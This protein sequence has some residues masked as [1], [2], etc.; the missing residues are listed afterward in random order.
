M[1]MPAPM[2]IALPLVVL[3][4]LPAAPQEPA[5]WEQTWQRAAT[6]MTGGKAAEAIA[7]LEPVVAKAPAFEAAEYE[8]GRAHE[9]RAGEFVMANTPDDPARRRHLEQ[10][11]RLY[12][13][14]A[15][16]N[17]QYRLPA[18]GWLMWIYDE[19]DLDK[20]VERAVAARDYIAMSPRSAL[21]YVARA[22]ALRAAGQHDAAWAVLDTARAAVEPGDAGS[23][24][25]AILLHLTEALP[26]V[27]AGGTPAG[28]A[29]KELARL[30]DYAD[31]TLARELAEN[32]SDRGAILAKAA[33]L[34]LRAQRL[35]RDPAKRKALE[36]EAEALLG[37]NRAASAAS[38]PLAFATPA[39]PAGDP[40]PAGY[41]E[42]AARATT[43]VERKQFAEAMAIYDGFIASHPGFAPSH[44]QRVDVLIRSGQGALVAPALRA[45]RKAVAGTYESRQTG[46]TYLE[47]IV[48]KN[49]AISVADGTV[50]LGEALVLVDEALAA[51]PHDVPALVYK[52]LIVRGQ[53]RFAPD[54]AAAQKLTAEA[55]RL[56][57][58]AQAVRTQP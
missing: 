35:E 13:R 53:A 48:R 29:P 25:R 8:L 10:A 37:R 14:V 38:A 7:L 12:Q 34:S 9:F 21:G 11:A 31:A 55:D 3:S 4:V 16:R 28:T 50:A 33:S 19:D 30:L 41:Y 20:P 1:P 43:L 46:A 54:A 27:T 40:T 26:F 57:A 18:L 23:L 22:A 45:A 44:Y 42:A 5:G 51:K 15:D 36:A 17:G 47:E 52:S 49:P 2:L 56:R 6:L 39:A 32:A 58:A 24:T